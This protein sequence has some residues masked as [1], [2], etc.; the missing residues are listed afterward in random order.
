MAVHCPLLEAPVACDDPGL[1][2]VAAMAAGIAKQAIAAAEAAAMVIARFPLCFS[3]NC[4]VS[5]FVL[6]NKY[7]G[8]MF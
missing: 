7:G 1:A 6:A 4:A 8:A 3:F 5:D 2:A